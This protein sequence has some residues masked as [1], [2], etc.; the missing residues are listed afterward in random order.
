MVTFKLVVQD[1]ADSTPPSFT[2]TTEIIINI[3]DIDNRPPWFQPCKLDVTGH[4]KICLGEGYHG[5]VTLTEQTAGILPLEPSPMYAVDGDKDVNAEISYKILSG[6]VNDIFYIGGDSGNITMLK[7]ADVA[8]PIVLNIMLQ[9]KCREQN[10]PLYMVFID[11]KKAFDSVNR[12]T[13]WLVLTKNVCP[14]K[15]VQVL[16][17]LHDNMS[18]TVLTGF[19]DDTDPFHVDT[20]VKQGCV[21]APSLFSIFIAGILHLTEN[22]LPQE[23]KIMYRSDELLNINRFRAKGQTTT[24]CVTELQYA[25][26]NAIVAL[27]EEDLQ[28]TL[29]AFAYQ[30]D[31]ADQFATTTVTFQ[32]MEKSATPPRFEKDVYEGH[33]SLDAGVGSL[34]LEGKDSTKPLLVQAI[35]EDY[36]DGINPN[37][38][39]ELEGSTEFSITQQGFII[40][41]TKA[42]PGPV[43]FKV[44]AMDTASG[45]EVVTSVDVEVAPETPTTT[46]MPSTTADMSTATTEV[47]T[48]SA[49]M[50]D[51]SLTSA[52]PT[53]EGAKIGVYSVEDMAAVGATLGVLLLICIALIAVMAVHVKGHSSHHKKI[54]EISHFHSNLASASAGMK[55]GVQYSNE[56]FQYDGDDGASSA[57]GGSR[58]S[59]ESVEMDQRPAR[60]RAGAGAGGD[61]HYE[62]VVG[63]AASLA[64]S[65]RSGDTEGKEVK[66]ILTKERRDDEKEGY[67]AVWFKQDIDPNTKGEEVT[68]IPDRTEQ[69]EDDDNDDDREEDDESLDGE[70]SF[71]RSTGT[72]L[73]ANSDDDD[74][75]DYHPQTSDL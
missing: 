53:Q 54:K 14:D 31:N 35:D 27:S 4:I 30:T 22:Q 16:R 52:A 43:S 40:M 13:L 71:P 57:S 64:E 10:Q 72:N 60:A 73:D 3:N 15:Y 11:L 68:I 48:S 45:D 25:D 58:L 51:S 61:P 49:A 55:E 50:T 75:D 42:P 32:V 1:T 34:V 44:R 63:D 7:P 36:A 26:D 37:V 67:K 20:G 9:E 21:I 5:K 66:P 12:Q 33:I 23:V 47:V 46:A 8:G 62:T 41:A 65:G 56:G 24:A 28:Y 6:N 19:G 70:P 17:L 2:T 29:N 38:E 59:V 39:Y 69:D 74:D 18:A